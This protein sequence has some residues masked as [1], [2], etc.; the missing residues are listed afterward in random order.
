MDDMLKFFEDFQNRTIYKKLT[1]EIL[2]DIPN[3]QL[4]QTIYDNIYEIIGYDYENEFQNVQKLTKGQQAFVST[5]L[6][7]V[8][9]NNGGFNQFYFNSSGQYA[10]MAVDGFETVGALKFAELMKEANKIYA[11]IKSDLEKFDDSTLESFS[12]SYKENPLNNLD[13]QFYDQD[14][15]E[16][17]WKFRVKY[18]RENIDQFITK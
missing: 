6:V 8:E 10:Y 9:V 13:D 7:E 2:K 12:E 15:A 17:L 3:D 1:P 4:E 18:I 11:S 5:W 14:K 16:P